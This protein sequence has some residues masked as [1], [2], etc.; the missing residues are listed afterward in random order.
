MQ[1]LLLDYL[2]QVP[3]SSKAK[4]AELLTS[5]VRGISL[6]GTSVNKGKKK[7]GQSLLEDSSPCTM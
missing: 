2:A 3:E 1:Y 7:E 5:E 4:F 6:L